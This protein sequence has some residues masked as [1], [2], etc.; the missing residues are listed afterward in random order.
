MLLHNYALAG[1][2]IYLTI[3]G[4]KFHSGSEKIY[5]KLVEK[6]VIDRD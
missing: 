3:V 4:L 5:S 6:K 2:N 1:K